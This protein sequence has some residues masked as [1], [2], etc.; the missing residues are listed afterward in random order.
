[1][2]LRRITG[3]TTVRRVQEIIHEMVIKDRIQRFY[4]STAREKT[5]LVK[6]KR[7]HGYCG[8]SPSCMEY[9]GDKSLCS[10]CS[11]AKDNPMYSRPTW[12]YG[13][14]RADEKAA[15]RAAKLEKNAKERK[16]APP[17]RRAA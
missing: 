3:E 12:R 11:K 6:Y 1:M 9:T 5:A 13:K 15:E 7:E 8:G 16:T 2:G 17:K 10:R 4:A 14:I